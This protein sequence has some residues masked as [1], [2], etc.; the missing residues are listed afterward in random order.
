MMQRLGSIYKDARQWIPWERARST[1]GV[2]D[3]GLITRVTYKIRTHCIFSNGNKSERNHEE[4]FSHDGSSM[5][6]EPNQK[7]K[8]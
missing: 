6:T 3:V 5:L 8:Y 7:I 2:G 4:Y 1:I